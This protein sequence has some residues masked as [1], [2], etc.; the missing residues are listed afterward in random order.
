MEA[1]KSAQGAS[2]TTDREVSLEDLTRLCEDMMKAM[3]TQ[4]SKT[5]SSSFVLQFVKQKYSVTHERAIVIAQALIE[6]K[7]LFPLKSHTFDDNE[8]ERYRFQNDPENLKNGRA[9]L[10][11]KRSK[12]ITERMSRKDFVAQQYA[13]EILRKNSSEKLENH[14]QQLKDRKV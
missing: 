4:I 11:L 2:T 6:A 13:E 1:S 3:K 12:S 14:C 7:L 9:S 10:T 5:V 8:T